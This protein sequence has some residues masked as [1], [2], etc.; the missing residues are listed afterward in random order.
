MGGEFMIMMSIFGILILVLLAIT[1][2]AYFFSAIGI[3]TIAKRRGIQNTWLAFIPIAQYYII[4]EIVD[5]I[6]A[7]KQKE[8]KYKFILLGIAIASAVMGGTGGAMGELIA[9]AALV[10]LA[11]RICILICLF[12]IYKDYAPGASVVYLVFSTIFYIEAA[13]LFFIRKKVPVSMCFSPM[14][15]WQFEANAPQ[16][17]MLWEQYHLTLQMQS[18]SQFLMMNFVPIQ[19]GP[20]NGF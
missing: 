12:N 2:V 9:L 18:W 13:F 14:D 8:T 7:Y 5:N 6:N 20:N 1:I 17:Q 11:H 4:G 3:S 16:L 10:S 19:Q 15:A